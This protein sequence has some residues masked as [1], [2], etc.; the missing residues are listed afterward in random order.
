[1]NK[2]AKALHAAPMPLH[3]HHL[4]DATGLPF[5]LVYQELVHLEARGEARPLLGYYPRAGAVALAGWVGTM[6]SPLELS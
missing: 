6:N 3:V 2:V 5:E 1:M 4:M